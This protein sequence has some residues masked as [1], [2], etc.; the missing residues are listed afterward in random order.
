MGKEKEL[1][2]KGRN[3]KGEDNNENDR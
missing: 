3:R 1:R 2:E